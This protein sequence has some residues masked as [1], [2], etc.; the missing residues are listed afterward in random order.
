MRPKS[1]ILIIIALGC[2]LIASIG[3]SQ[4]MESRNG[5]A[6]QAVPMAKV[7]VATVDIP[8][9]EILEPKMVK[10]EEWPED[11]VPE[12][13]VRKL[14][15]LE[16]KR[17][18]TRLY[19]GE[20]ILAAKLIDANKFYGAS[21]KIP[22]GYRVASVKVTVDS[23]A[24]GLLNPG[25]RVDVL[26]FLK[27][28]RGVTMTGTRTIL[29]N[30]TVFAVND[31]FQR[32]PEEDAEGMR[33]KTVSLL[34]KPDQVEKIMLASELGKIK[35]SLR[36][37]D[38]DSDGLAR[39]ATI[40]DLFSGSQGSV[41]IARATEGVPALSGGITDFLKGMK[42]LGDASADTSKQTWVMRIHTPNDIQVFNW[43]DRES[44]PRELLNSTTS[45]E[46]VPVDVPEMP[47]TALDPSGGAD[48]DGTILD[49]SAELDSD[50]DLSSTDSSELLT[51]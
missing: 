19:P 33:A 6:P 15:D 36:R 2:G 4:V 18:L 11:K 5:D 49:D 44:L 48:L 27:K 35:L 38:D 16:G 13:V 40:A 21:E 28:R 32:D 46:M 31:Q 3:I 43:D 47:T 14:E 1:M 10:I 34:V 50:A 9:G 7:Y 41:A 30:I 8:L 20:P 39:G 22:K 24:S 51:D 29:R 12:G 42:A 23:S 37:S 25:D 17:P 26:V 45:A